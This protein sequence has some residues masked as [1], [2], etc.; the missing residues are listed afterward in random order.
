MKSILL[1]SSNKVLYTATLLVA[2]FIIQSNSS[3]QDESSHS[4]DTINVLNNRLKLILPTGSFQLIEK[5]QLQEMY[6]D[7]FNEGKILYANGFRFGENSMVRFY[8]TTIDYPNT[9]DNALSTW[10]LIELY[11]SKVPQGQWMESGWKRITNG[12][13]YFVKIVS[14]EKPE[15]LF[16]FVF[17]YID[18]K[19]CFSLFQCPVQEATPYV[20]EPRKN[21]NFVFEI[22]GLHK[23]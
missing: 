14:H 3:A 21:M 9:N 5:D 19:L 4:M 2:L 7:S 23:K 15:Q 1:Y 17:F 13:L 20:Y 8:Q 11:T 6:K 10:K 12:H 18:A 16:K 22:A